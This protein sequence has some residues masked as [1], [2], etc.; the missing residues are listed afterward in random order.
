[1]IGRFMNACKHIQGGPQA[2]LTG[3]NRT[4]GT[5][6]RGVRWVHHNLRAPS[7]SL[8]T[9]TIA[10]GGSTSSTLSCKGLTWRT[11][12]GAVQ[13]KRSKLQ[14][15]GGDPGDARGQI[16]PISAD[17]NWCLID[18]SLFV[19]QSKLWMQSAHISF[20]IKLQY[21]SFLLPA[22]D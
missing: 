10:T 16:D 2:P 17:P 22:S 15:L 4:M 12:W 5:R 8:S 1:M 19:V 14:D 11:H 20:T 6:G 3:V 9:S 7:H 13:C 21:P 18:N